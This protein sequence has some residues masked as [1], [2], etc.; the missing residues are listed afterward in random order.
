M[1][2]RSKDIEYIQPLVCRMK[3]CTFE[4]GE[5]F[6]M[7]KETFPKIRIRRSLFT[8]RG[9]GVERTRERMR[10]SEDQVVEIR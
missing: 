10:V 4:H 3:D 8:R 6:N 2:G 7:P 9:G 1:K 5:G